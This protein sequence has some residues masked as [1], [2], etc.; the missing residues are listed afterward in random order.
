MTTV[1]LQ[2]RRGYVYLD[3]APLT[4]PDA[5]NGDDLVGALN[6]FCFDPPAEDGTEFELDGAVVARK[7]DGQ[8]VAA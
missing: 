8:V 7:I 2:H 1:T 4:G 5:T 6:A 3:D